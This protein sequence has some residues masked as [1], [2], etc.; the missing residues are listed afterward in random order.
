[1][2]NTKDSR[3][4]ETHKSQD[5]NI[6]HNDRGGWISNADL[7]G[8]AEKEAIEWQ[9][10]LKAGVTRERRNR[11]ATTPRYEEHFDTRFADRGPAGWG[12]LVAFYDWSPND[13]P[14]SLFDRYGR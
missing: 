10:Q 13:E 6:V 2:R 7:L 8:D 14:G 11:P 9:K 5:A 12:H 4:G 3:K 1:M